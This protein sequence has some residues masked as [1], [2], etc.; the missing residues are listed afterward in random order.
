MSTRAN[1][2]IIHRADKLGLVQLHQLRGRVGRSYHQAYAY[3]FFPREVKLKKVAKKRLEAIQKMDQL[4]SGLFLAIQD[5][6]IR[7]AGEILGEEQSGEIQ[8]IGYELLYNKL[9]RKT[10]NSLKRNSDN[11]MNDINDNIVEIKMN[12]SS[13]LPENYRPNTHERLLIYK[14]F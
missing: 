10:I 7:G 14:N 3:L 12:E 1:T 2:I 9:L 13:L 5:L 11:G 6:E 8:K 4:G